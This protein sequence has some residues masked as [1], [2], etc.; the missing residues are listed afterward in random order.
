[1][2]IYLHIEV[3]L[4]ELD[5]KLLLA[6]L[7]AKR[8]H[9]VILG[10]I[11][12]LEAGAS[13]GALR[14]S[15]VLTT[16][17]TPSTKKI[18]RHRMLQNHSLTITSI[19]EESGLAHVSDYEDFSRQRYSSE[20]LEQASAAFCWGNEDT[21]ALRRV[22]PEHASKVVKTGSPRVDLW[23]P[24]FREYWEGSV[25]RPKNPYLLVS[26]NMSASSIVPIPEAVRMLR[27][28]GYFSRDESELYRFIGLIG[29]QW[30]LIASFVE[31]ISYLSANSSGFDI[32]LRPHPGEDTE[33]WKILLDGL[34]NVHVIR[35]GGI[36]SWVNEA[37]VV[38]HNGCTTAFE[39]TVA[40]TPVIA[41][42]PFAQEYELKAPNDLGKR[43]SSPGGLLDEVTKLFQSHQVSTGIIEDLRSVPQ[44]LVEKIH[45][46]DDELAAEKIIRVWES[47]EI[48]GE[49]KKTDLRRFRRVLMR[50]K[51]RSFPATLFHTLGGRSSQGSYSSQKFAGFDLSEIQ[52]KV[53]RLV[54]VLD[55]HATIQVKRLSKTVIVVKRVSG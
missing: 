38:M 46:E 16:S 33:T 13:H 26:S 2:I 49:S 8:G 35:E 39:A 14:G 29:E 20:T 55:I 37:F 24:R 18:T 10:D 5:S 21:E 11:S 52:A 3:L 40:G 36:T 41:Y 34:P 4:R 45:I 15:V 1:M 28:A 9:Q 54:G 25:G 23:R 12:A 51:I 7:A 22:Y 30:R 47:L 42:T 27:K 44:G 48:A 32:V 17:L 31:A 19:D 50:K 53:E 6:V 43:I